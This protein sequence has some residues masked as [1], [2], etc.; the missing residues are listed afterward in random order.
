MTPAEARRYFGIPA[1]ASAAVV[2]ARIADH[3]CE[4]HYC[5]QD[6]AAPA[7][8]WRQRGGAAREALAALLGE[9]APRA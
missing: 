3:M 9:E 7:C 8:P 6:C 4:S 1:G 2:A 5:A